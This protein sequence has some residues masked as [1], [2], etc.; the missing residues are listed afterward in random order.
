[1]AKLSEDGVGVEYLEE[2]KLNFIYE[3]LSISIWRGLGWVR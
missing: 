3:C 2:E 1:M